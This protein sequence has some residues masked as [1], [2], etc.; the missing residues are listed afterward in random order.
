MDAVRGRLERMR[1]EFCELVEEEGLS[2]LRLPEEEREDSENG[3]IEAD[4]GGPSPRTRA[5]TLDPP[6]GAGPFSPTRLVTPW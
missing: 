3:A 4:R 6:P 1:A 5:A 2:H